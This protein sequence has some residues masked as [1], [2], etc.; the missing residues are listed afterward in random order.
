M[1]RDPDAA[2]RE[3]AQAGIVNE[4]ADQPTWVEVARRFMGP[5]TIAMLRVALE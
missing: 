1:Q 2:V 4:I 5:R 3:F